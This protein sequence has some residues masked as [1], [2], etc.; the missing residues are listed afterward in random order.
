MHWLLFF[1]FYW[2]ALSQLPSWSWR[3]PSC[4]PATPSARNRW[5]LL[6]GS[7]EWQ[8]RPWDWRTPT[9][10]SANARSE[11]LINKQQWPWRLMMSRLMRKQKTSG[12]LF[13]TLRPVNSADSLSQSWRWCN[14]SPQRWDRSP[15]G[16][17]WCRWLVRRSEES[18]GEQEESVLL[19]RSDRLV[20]I[21]YASFREMKHSQGRMF[22]YLFLLLFSGLCPS[23]LLFFTFASN[24]WRVWRRERRHSCSI[25]T[26]IV[27]RAVY[28]HENY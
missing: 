1:L 2:P 25:P 27:L 12:R 13:V 19:M 21:E 5:Q 6:P 4:F 24:F 8:C 9:G 23:S 18:V 14:R 16:W 28:F 3:S 11:S 7:P 10:C 20:R 22:L 15:S 17:P 26:D